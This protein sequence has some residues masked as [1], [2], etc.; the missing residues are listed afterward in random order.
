M[1]Q[2]SKIIATVDNVFTSNNIN[3]QNNN[4]EKDKL[5]HTEKKLFNRFKRIKSKNNSKKNTIYNTPVTATDKE[6]NNSTLKLYS[7]FN[8]VDINSFDS[9]N[10]IYKDISSSLNPQGQPLY[11]NFYFNNVFKYIT[12]ANADDFIKQVNKYLDDNIAS[13]NFD[14]LIESTITFFTNDIT[15]KINTVNNI[16]PELKSSLML[17]VKSQI[18]NLCFDKIYS[19]N[20]K[21][22]NKDTFKLLFEYMSDYI[23]TCKTITCK[24]NEDKLLVHNINILNKQ[25]IFK[26]IANIVLFYDDVDI[27]NHVSENIEKCFTHAFPYHQKAK[28]DLKTKLIMLCCN[29]AKHNTHKN[30]IDINNCVEN[31]IFYIH[32]CFKLLT[33]KSTTASTSINE[34]ALM[35]CLL[36]NEVIN[37]IVDSTFS[38]VKGILVSGVIPSID[39][40]ASYLRD[41]TSTSNLITQISILKVISKNMKLCNAPLDKI[42]NSKIDN[43]GSILGAVRIK[44]C[45]D[46]IFNNA[47]SAKLKIINNNNNQDA[48]LLSYINN[49][50][51]NNL[52]INNSYNLNE[53]LQNLNQNETNVCLKHLLEPN[54][55]KSYLK[56][57]NNQQSAIYSPFYN[58]P[59]KILMDRTVSCHSQHLLKLIQPVI[60][61]LFKINK[62]N[63][64]I[65]ETF[66]TQKTLLQSKIDSALESLNGTKFKEE[67]HTNEFLELMFNRDCDKPYL[68]M[69]NQIFLYLD[70]FNLLK[71][72][73]SKHV[74]DIH[75]N[76]YNNKVNIEE[77]KKEAEILSFFNEIKNCYLSSVSSFTNATM[78]SNEIKYALN[79]LDEATKRQDNNIPLDNNMLLDISLISALLVKYPNIV[80][81]LSSMQKVEDQIC[82][83][84][85]YA[86]L[87][88]AKQINVFSYC[89][90]ILLNECIN[91]AEEK[92]NPQEIY[93]ILDTILEVFVNNKKNPPHALIVSLARERKKSNSF[94]LLLRSDNFLK[95]LLNY[96][97][98]KHDIDT[99][100]MFD[101][102]NSYESYNGRMMGFSIVRHLID[103]DCAITEANRIY[104]LI[105]NH[106]K[107]KLSKLDNYTKIQQE[108]ISITQVISKLITHLDPLINNTTGG[109]PENKNEIITGLNILIKQFSNCLYED[110]KEYIKIQENFSDIE[111]RKQ[112][113]VEAFNIARQDFVI[114]V[115]RFV[116]IM[117]KSLSKNNLDHKK[118]FLDVKEYEKM[119]YSSILID[120]LASKR[121]KGNKQ[122][123]DRSKMLFEIFNAHR[124]PS[125]FNKD[126]IDKI[127]NNVFN[128]IK[129]G[130]FTS[131]YKGN[132]KL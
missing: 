6:N 66:H 128:N 75:L 90:S 70:N 44:E 121:D 32:E 29:F 65:G 125:D 102:S 114:N 64:V 68:E 99:N 93:K 39:A 74:F 55:S 126:D 28:I 12:N 107:T 4:L 79:K 47:L 58:A 11:N 92:G 20:K 72:Y 71:L 111:K 117:Q 97:L 130:T 23:A 105:M 13:G 31:N 26:H 19:N 25:N 86:F 83:L 1:N 61:N 115:F 67:F 91:F 51:E 76:N 103:S 108:I 14:V 37:N 77:N 81:E 35:Q 9:Q 119:I 62:I 38:R 129:T 73:P 109:L 56:Y 59:S 110:L 46:L 104:E 63:N 78:L 5:I 87:N 106:Y 54:V 50:F 3:D 80:N 18:Y 57:Y 94:N 52:S 17:A 8:H 10:E 45:I 100:V 118:N 48:L 40:H 2:D 42:I 120:T 22:N 132:L 27:S 89:Y 69:F 41:I 60:A 95:V 49:L 127:I 84:S 113:K 96:D 7:K 124:I 16:S 53:M 88:S 82:K 85:S 122:Y 33:F 123:K 24:P 36:L 101:I 131:N 21:I 116:D 98:N 30:I 34:F 112:Y 15:N 43:N